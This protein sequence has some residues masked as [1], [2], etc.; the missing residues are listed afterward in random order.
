MWPFTRK[1][2]INPQAHTASDDPDDPGQF[3]AKRIDDNLA[4]TASVNRR[5]EVVAYSP[6]DRAV[7]I[8][9]GV[10]THL[11]CGGT[12]TV[13]TRTDELVDNRRTRQILDVLCDTADGGITS[14]SQLIEDMA[15][16]YLLDGNALLLPSYGMD[17]TVSQLTRYRSHDAYTLYT[18]SG[19]YVY[20]ASKAD[21]EVGGLYTIP[22]RDMIHI[23]WPRLL[24]SHYS[25]NSREMF[26][27]SPIVA[28]GR[29]LGIGLRS[30]RY[31]EDWYKDGSKPT[32][33]FNIEE[34]EGVAGL[35]ADQRL[36]VYNEIRK[37]AQGRE[38][39]V[40]FNAKSTVLDT[41]PQDRTSK[42]LREFQVEETARHYGLPLPL[43]SVPIGQWAR[44]VNEQVMKMAW[45]T[46]FLPHINRM[47]MPM[48]L[49]LLLRG[50]RFNVDPVGLI[51]GDAAGLAQLSKAWLGDAQSDQVA[52][53]REIRH[54]G[55][56][57]RTPDGPLK[58]RAMKPTKP[59]PANKP[60]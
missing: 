54:L 5:N 19:G 57:P 58:E 39:F 17:G 52:S 49:R 29:A 12:L 18:S 22:G 28:L 48:S 14:A 8:I 9:S 31:V 56:L 59:A 11:I 16:D 10:A 44:G 50:E 21:M 1:T 60:T 35:T 41:T 20:Y 30:D 7:T 51:R 13:R 42:E 34:K 43:L 15:L 47:L 37:S 33:H 46:C 24:R 3:F 26:A 45:Q 23:R 36:E 40:T 2:S 4:L 25:A 32:V 55:G 38:P 27:L 53:I 6:L